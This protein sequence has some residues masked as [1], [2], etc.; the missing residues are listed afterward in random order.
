METDFFTQKRIELMLEMVMKKYEAELNGIKQ[1]MAALNSEVLSL[2]TGVNIIPVHPNVH[3][4]LQTSNQIAENS[5]QAVQQK[6][7]DIV[8]LRPKD[9]RQKEFVSGAARN[10][11][12]L[13]PRYGDYKSEDVSIEK[14]F[15]FGN[16][17]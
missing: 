15:Y 1:S 12:P 3:V 11:E 4:S 13:R 7:I 5:E 6:K 16:K 8:D 10:T 2:R 9:E 14:F 17:K